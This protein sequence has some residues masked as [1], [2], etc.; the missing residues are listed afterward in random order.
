[1]LFPF[2][3]G[4]DGAGAERGDG[5]QEPDAEAGWE[6]GWEDLKDAPRV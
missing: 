5:M 1:M 4:D 2:N 3:E 6:R